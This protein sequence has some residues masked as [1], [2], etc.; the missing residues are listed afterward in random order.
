V[1]NIEESIAALTQELQAEL[2]QFAAEAEASIETYVANVNAQPVPLTLYHYTDAVG[3]LPSSSRIYCGFAGP[4]AMTAGT[5]SGLM[6]KAKNVK[7]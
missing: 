4:P 2:R 1:A 7:G 5:P 3:L 6:L